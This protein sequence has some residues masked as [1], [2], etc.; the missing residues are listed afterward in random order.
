MDDE[1]QF[2]WHALQL[3]NRSLKAVGQAWQDVFSDVMEISRP[4]DFV[5]V[6][7]GGSAGDLKCDGYLLSDGTIYQCYGPRQ[8]RDAPATAKIHEDFHGAHG[9]WGDRMKRWL[10][11]NNSPDGITGAV[12]EVLT[13]LDADHDGIK[14]GPFGLIDLRAELK[15]APA[16]DRDR[17]L[18]SA[19]T[20]RTI[21]NLRRED[22]SG[23]IQQIGRLP[24]PA[25]ADM[26]PVPQ[27]KMQYNLL[28]DDAQTLLMAGI[29]KSALVKSYFDNHYNPQYRDEVAARMSEEYR[30][31]R[32]K[33]VAADDI[34]TE[35]QVF[36]GGSMVAPSA[37]HQAAV[38]AIVTYFFSECDIFERPIPLAS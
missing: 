22:L 4:G 5:R 24:A 35:L 2:A 26:R 20:T 14:V 15:T 29:R 17:L 12:L 19:P 27:N 33:N 32:A 3:E 30:H 13:Q 9:H 21:A 1:V 11:V 16:S 25:D 31:L 38:L 28:S 34:L 37:S 8:T 10:Y 23:L 18:G 36:V 6:R 7:A